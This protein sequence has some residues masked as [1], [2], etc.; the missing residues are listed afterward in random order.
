MVGAPI[1]V[2]VALPTGVVWILLAQPERE[3]LNGARWG[4]AFTAAAAVGAVSLVS[5]ASVNG[6]VYVCAAAAA[7]CAY[8]GGP[9]L[10]V[11]RSTP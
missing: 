2:I 3:A 5:L 8:Y 4:A 11:W 1:G 7:I 6:F 10:G 9:R